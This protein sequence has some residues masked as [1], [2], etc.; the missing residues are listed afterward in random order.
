MENEKRN[1]A[2]E[3]SMKLFI[4]CTEQFDLNKLV[5]LA[6]TIPTIEVNHTTRETL[7]RLFSVNT[8]INFCEVNMKNDNA[9]LDYLSL[10]IGYS[11][12][13]N[14]YFITLYNK[15]YGTNFTIDDIDWS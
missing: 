7:Y 13:P 1:M 5:E 15:A 11:D 12:R 4:D 9:I 2:R 8:P 3:M 14:E 10:A 6:Q